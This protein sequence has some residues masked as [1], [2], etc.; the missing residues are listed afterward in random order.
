[1]IYSN[2]LSISQSWVM[3]ERLPPI[4]GGTLVHLGMLGLLA[5]LLWR[6]ISVA[7]L[8]RLKKA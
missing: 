7:P 1:M 6:R 5:I 4:V 8:L 3:Q 2:L